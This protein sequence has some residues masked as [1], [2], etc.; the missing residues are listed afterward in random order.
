MTADLKNRDYTLI[1]D[2][3]GSM[4]TPDVNGRSRWEAIK[5]TTQAFAH[6]IAEL[7]PDGINV[8]AFSGSFKFYQNVGPDMVGKIFTENEPGGGTNLAG[9]LTDALRAFQA[10][11]D[12][13]EYG[14]DKKKGETIIVVTDGIPDDTKAVENVIIEAAKKVGDGETLAL[15]FLQIGSD[16]TAS[17][18]LK[19]LDDDLSKSGI[20]DIVDAKTF[21]DL[22]GMTMTEALLAA[23]N[24]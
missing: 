21:A 2:K 10:R 20:P 22:D 8:Y 23:I 7:D 12:A 6:K 5:E 1:I 13:G 17:E 14:P 18:F 11:K 15:S 19:R 4:Q 16:H 9:V 24:D 3:S